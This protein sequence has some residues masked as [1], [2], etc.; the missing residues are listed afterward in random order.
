MSRLLFLLLLLLPACAV[1]DP[2]QEVSCGL[3]LRTE[4]PVTILRNVPLV[5]VNINGLPATLILD[6]GAQTMLLTQS[7]VKRLGLRTDGRA[8]MTV[9]G[10][11]GETRSWPAILQ[12]F[13]VGD[14]A[15][16]DQ[17]AAVL[18]FDLPEIAGTRPE[19]LLG[20]DVLARF[21]VDLD[22]PGRRMALYS[23][24]ACEGEPLPMPGRI[25][26]VEAPTARRNRLVIEAELDG[27]PM[28]ALLDSGTQ[29]SIVM[30]QAA[31][32]TP[33]MLAGDP[34]VML[35]GAGPELA[36]G[37]RHRFERLVLAGESFREVRLTVMQRQSDEDD[38]I[39]GMDYMAGRRIWL[40]YPRRK[41]FIQRLARPGVPVAAATAQ[42]PVAAAAADDAG[43]RLW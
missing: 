21:E 3:R 14:V 1:L 28:T 2:D 35:R 17:H 31:R 42:M 6:T 36:E 18:P 24:R 30:A 4:I 37:R 34:R 7:A 13:A 9:R 12:R 16:P 22:M 33:K 23:G 29:D 11:G 39:I 20:V 26:E 32:L 25:V 27:R 40:A 15:L 41:V 19:G 10:T 43:R 8:P 5:V 38:M